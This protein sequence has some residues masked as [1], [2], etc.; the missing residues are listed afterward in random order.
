MRL[1]L[2][3]NIMKNEKIEVSILQGFLGSLS[4][5]KGLSDFIGILIYNLKRGY[6]LVINGLGLKQ[7]RSKFIIKSLKFW[8]ELQKKDRYKLVTFLCLVSPFPQ[9][10][11]N[12]DWLF[13]FFLNIYKIVPPPHPNILSRD[14]SLVFISLLPTNELH[15]QFF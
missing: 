2:K 8:Y 15:Y 14:M 5:Q 4:S 3:K 13:D 6:F 1:S 7:Y 12:R 10:N 11:N 9:M